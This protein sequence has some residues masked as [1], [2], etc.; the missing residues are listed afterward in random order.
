VDWW[1]G[2]QLENEPGYTTELLTQYATDF[3]ARNKDGTFFLYLT[4]AAPHD[5]W[6]GRNP[7]E[8]K[9]P[10][11]IYGEMIEGLDA[12]VGAIVAALR[13]HQ[14]EENTLLIFCSD[15][16]GAP[17]RGVAANGRLQGRKGGMQEGGHRV[18][19]VAAWP[20]MIPPGRTSG[21]TV[22]TMDFF[23]TF[24][25][26][27]GAA[28]PPGHTID[29]MDLMPLLR[30]QAGAA[31]RDLHWLFGDAWAVRQGPWKLIGRGEAALSLVNL[32]NDPAE[33]GN[34]LREQPERVD[35]MMKLHRQWIAAVG[36]R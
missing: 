6:Q 16:G 24:A 8:K 31:D 30:N 18:P 11:A 28:I 17:P 12:S 14:L 3:I 32:D 9:S 20:G 33:G 13:R 19:C 1:R 36:G 25:Q 4:H 10:A 23:P 29:G 7:S 34:L 35:R 27:A 5:P 21:V 15:N 2:K 26:M 22:M